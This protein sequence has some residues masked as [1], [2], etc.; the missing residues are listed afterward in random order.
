MV[1]CPLAPQEV[2]SNLQHLL[3]FVSL[4]DQM[5]ALA[6]RFGRGFLEAAF[7]GIYRQSFGDVG[8]PLCAA[9]AG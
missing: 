8:D 3:H 1:R 9:R 2:W 6:L 5:L 7:Y 4:K